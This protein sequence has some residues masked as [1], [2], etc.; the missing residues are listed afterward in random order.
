MADSPDQRQL[1]LQKGTYLTNDMT[2]TYPTNRKHIP[3]EYELMLT[4]AGAPAFFELARLVI[5]AA[6][7]DYYYYYYHYY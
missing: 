7:V 3:D 1:K 6:S 4:K 5:V 2:K